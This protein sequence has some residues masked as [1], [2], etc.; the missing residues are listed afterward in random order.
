VLLNKDELPALKNILEK[1]QT[2]YEF[3]ITTGFIA[4]SPAK[5]QNIYQYYAAFYGLNPYPFKKCN[6]PWVS[7]VI[8]A[9]G[10]VKPCFFHNAIGNIH[11]ESLTNILNDEKG[12]R[13]R[14]E[15]D[16]NNNEICRRCVCYLNLPPGMNLK[17]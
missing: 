7:A 10:T 15:L 5:L 3:D 16:I 13:F 4:E 11:D 1:I 9:D 17:S 6:A 12:L 8:E 14:K 2:V